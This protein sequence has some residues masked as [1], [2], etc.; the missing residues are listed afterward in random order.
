VE[1]GGEG[2]DWRGS[3]KQQ[4]FGGRNVMAWGYVGWNCIGKAEENERWVCA[5]KWVNILDDH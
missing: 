2:V 5:N 1:I 3:R 4:N